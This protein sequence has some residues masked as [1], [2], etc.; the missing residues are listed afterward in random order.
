[1]NIYAWTLTLNTGHLS[2][3]FSVGVRGTEGFS[4][5]E[6]Y[7]EVT[8]LEPPTGTSVMVGVGTKKAALHLDNY[9]YVDLLGNVYTGKPN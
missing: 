7:W 6:H 2:L 9:Q 4:D 3:L 8:F 1:M 5:G